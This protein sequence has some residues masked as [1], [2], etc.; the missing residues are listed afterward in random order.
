MGKG[1]SILRVFFLA[2][3]SMGLGHVVFAQQYNNANLSTGANSNSG[4]AA[5][6]GFTWSECQNPTGNT[7]IANTN[8]GF[9]AQITANNSLADDFT[10]TGS[11]W[12]L[13]K[14]TVFAYSTGFTGSTSPFTDL[15]VR[16]HTSNPALGPTTVVFG[17]LTTN[18]LSASNGTTMYRIFNTVVAP[19]TAP[20]TT[21]RIWTLEANVNVTLN[22][23]TYWL[24]FQTGGPA[25]NFI[26]GATPIGVR[27]LPG[28]N[29]VQNQAGT[30]GALVDA[31]QG[32]ASPAN[33]PMDVPFVLDYTT[34]PCAGTPAP[35]NTIAS[36]ASVCPTIPFTLTLQN[37]TPGAGVSYQ[38]QSGPSS[39]GPWTNI[40]GAIFS[41]Y[42]STLTAT[43]WYRCIVTCSGN[44]GTSNP[45][46]VA[47]TPPSGCYCLPPPSDC[48]D[49][50]VITRVRI[51]TLD[52]SSACSAN[53][54][55]NY[56]TTVTAPIIFSGAGNPITVNTPTIW[57]ENV[58]VWIDYNQ[59]GQFD[60]NEYTNVGSNAGNGG[61]I[62]NTIN[63]P[64]TAL[65]G[66]TRMRVRVRFGTGALTSAQACTGYS[67]GE[68]EDYNVNIQPCVTGVF[69]SHPASTS[70]TCGNNA[71]FS[72]AATG[73]LLTYTWQYRTTPTG[74][75]IDVTNGGVF[76]G[77]TTSTLTVSNVPGTFNGYQFR[78]LMRGGCTAVDFSNPATLT[79]NP[80][81]PVVNPASATICSGSI[82]TL[83]L[84]NS[85]SS[86]VSAVYPATAGLPLSI[87]DNSPTGATSSLTV[88]GIPTG[89]IVT[90]IGIKFSMTHTWVGDMVIN[91]RAPNGQVLNLVGALN[92]GT[93]S[94]GTAN[95]LNTVVDSISTT[96]MSGAPAPRTGSYR[97]DR[98]GI[99]GTL[100]P[101]P[102][103]TG[104]WS[105]LL[106]TLNGTW[107]LGMSDIGAGDLGTL[108][109][110]ELQITYVAAN[111]AQGVW[112]SAP[113]APNTMFT[114]AAATIPYT[115]TPATT[116]YVR[117]TVNT[118]YS[119]SYSTP[120][121]CQSAVT[122][123]PVNVTNPVT[124][125]AVS[126]ATRAV[127]LG[128]STTFTASVTGG[129][130]IT[131]QWERSTDGGLTY[132][133]ISG[134]TGTTLTVS[135]VTQNMNGYRY[136]VV[137]TA[138][139][140]GA[141]ISNVATLTVN[142]LPVVTISSP[143][144]RLVPG[145][146]TTITASSTPPAAANGWSWTYNG[147]PI[148][149]TG[150]TQVVNIDRLGA[151]QATVVDVNGCS[152]TSNVLTIGAEATDKLWIYPNP[153][154]NGA[155][156]VRLYFGGDLAEKRVVTIYNP[157]GQV[158]ESRDFTLVRGSAPY[159]RMDFNLGGGATAKGSYVI[160]VANIFT[161]KVVSGIILVQ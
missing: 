8:A 11:A 15:R 138:A 130:P 73:S 116:I 52:N 7:S 64:A 120:T 117:P 16:I 61:V 43:T 104:S 67:F 146:T 141:V 145:R 155:F 62:T 41:S 107:S 88:S 81:V 32:P 54:Y 48:S 59:N 42:N 144:V 152:N 154:V 113:A 3:L 150:N 40:P 69:T 106:G 83:S 86:P 56:T 28:Y 137:A 24:E 78:A 91:L 103:T 115:G 95:F 100:T 84:T 6:A 135:G 23:G 50:D 149:G 101:M 126:P 93:G 21:R 30:W 98:F 127:C 111:F 27:S 156:Q 46:Q 110:W 79:V 76:S 133:A 36:V 97:A 151:Y 108:T 53:G 22:P 72:V 159:Q 74:V 47:L 60:T 75:W 82:Q 153:T 160:K 123:V 157:L 2:L 131:Y 140:C 112:T 128:G 158:I 87:P 14:I 55:A 94:N 71:T 129:G 125:L 18:R 57:S 118:V 109:G 1:A 147:S 119:V 37:A 114:D 136:R 90:N 29:A 124:G 17:D 148:A 35:G 66:I 65:T 80:I 121:P 5:P 10:V 77:A 92:N 139:P 105:P 51:S 13:S 45:V 68:T 85:V 25:S 9:G 44:N 102:T 70:V 26:P 58:S 143:V 132:S 20:G 134:A 63:I 33:V 99:P 31:G 34:G 19:A 89:V 39:T 49:N 142:A 38:W 96:P 12:N 4:V 161:G 122:N